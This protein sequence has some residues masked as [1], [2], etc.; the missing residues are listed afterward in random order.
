[1]EHGRF[2]YTGE[3]GSLKNARGCAVASSGKQ[4]M[5]NAKFT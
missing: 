4:M 3:D 5:L 2:G 1:M